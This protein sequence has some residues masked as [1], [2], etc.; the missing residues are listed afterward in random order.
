M[1]FGAVAARLIQACSVAGEG[2]PLGRGNAVFR[3]KLGTTNT[4]AEVCSAAFKRNLA[5]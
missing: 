4:Y 1:G 2:S 3:L 5:K